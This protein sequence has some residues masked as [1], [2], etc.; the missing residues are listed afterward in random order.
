MQQRVQCWCLQIAAWKQQHSFSLKMSQVLQWECLAAVCVISDGLLAAEL[1]GRRR[2]AGKKALAG[3]QERSVRQARKEC[4][5]GWSSRH[6]QA[7]NYYS[8][9]R[10][11]GGRADCLPLSW[12]A[13]PLVVFLSSTQLDHVRMALDTR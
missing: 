1:Q 4:C 2:L 13:A 11:A 8:T 6:V 7:F 10:Q 5:V 3:R 9:V 12:Q